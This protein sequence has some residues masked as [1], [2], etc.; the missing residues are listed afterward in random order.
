MAEKR[1]RAFVEHT[2]KRDKSCPK[3]HPDTPVPAPPYLPS[4]LH[5]G[6]AKVPKKKWHLC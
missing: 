6:R 2:E 1:R 3:K 4:N 5:K